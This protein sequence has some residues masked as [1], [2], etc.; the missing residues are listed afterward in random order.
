MQAWK[1]DIKT[2]M[3]ICQKIILQLK[4][5]HSILFKQNRSRYTSKMWHMLN[6][7]KH[8]THYPI[9]AVLRPKFDARE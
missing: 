4:T 6:K 8:P 3:T 5:G 1:S 9:S 7:T 2:N